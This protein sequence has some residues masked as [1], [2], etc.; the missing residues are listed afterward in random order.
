MLKLNETKSSVVP[1]LFL[2][3]KHSYQERK[4]KEEPNPSCLWCHLSCLC[5]CIS[6]L[7]FLAMATNQLGYVSAFFSGEW[8]GGGTFIHIYTLVSGLFWEAAIN[9]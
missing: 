1:L 4:E 8:K 2:G 3:G 7:M 9:R 5:K 6:S